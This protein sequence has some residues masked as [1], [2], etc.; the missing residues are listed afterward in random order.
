[1]LFK[2]ARFTSV[3]QLSVEIFLSLI[4]SVMFEESDLETLITVQI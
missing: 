2:A 1:M 3:Q 4:L